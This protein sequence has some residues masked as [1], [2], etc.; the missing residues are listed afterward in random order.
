MIIWTKI[1]FTHDDSNI[2][3]T[4]RMRSITL[5]CGNKIKDPLFLNEAYV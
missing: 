1:N 3:E 4:E 2:A 5:C